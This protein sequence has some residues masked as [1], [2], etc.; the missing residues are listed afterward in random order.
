MNIFKK[1]EIKKEIK[2]DGF[3]NP[4]TRMGTGKDNRKRN[5]ITVNHDDVISYETFYDM[6]PLAKKIVDILPEEATRE[7]IELTNFEKEEKLRFTEELE[8]L[9][10]KTKFF[11]AGRYSRLYGAGCI[12][13]VDENPSIEAMSLPLTKVRGIKNLLLY[14]NYE[15]QPSN[16]KIEDLAD[17]D[18]GL[19]KYYRV[20]NSE[21]NSSLNYVDIHRSHFLFVQEKNISKTAF[22]MNNY[23]NF[24][25]LGRLSEAITD[26][27]TSNNYVPDIISKY[28]LLMIKMFGMIKLLDECF[29]KT[30][31]YMK[32]QEL[33]KDK[34]EELNDRISSLSVGIIDAEDDMVNINPSNIAGIKELFERI[35]KN[36]I[37]NCD[38]PHTILMCESPQGSNATGN[39]T[40]ND[41]YNKVSIWQEKN[42]RKPLTRLFKMMSEYLNIKD[43]DFEFAP[44]WQQTEKETAETKEITSRTDKNYIEMGVLAPEE[45]RESR[46]AGE[47]YSSDTTIEG[48]L[49][50]LPDEEEENKG[51]NENKK[52]KN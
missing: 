48:E 45:V 14:H 13:I 27:Q 41:W 43:F 31:D 10:V 2:K 28:N 8:R 33:I 40:T 25:I 52:T 17:P 4:Y 11:E 3:S 30:G 16:E 21:Q 18:F 51:N 22:E 34:I 1:K 12:L 44:L 49:P 24:G 26:W 46:F 15:L 7:W 36:L 19:P 9:E 23:F 39:S 29:E 50:E 5:L 35:D 38:I 6:I 42:Y 47:L 37:V 32:G 20:I